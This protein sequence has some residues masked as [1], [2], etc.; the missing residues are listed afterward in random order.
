MLVALVV[1]ALVELKFKLVRR[2]LNDARADAVDL[3]GATFGVLDFAHL[4][5][6]LNA[7][8][9]LIRGLKVLNREFPLSTLLTQ[10]HTAVGL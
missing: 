8:H 6:E 3:G 9:I 10:A 4:L 7:V 1:L 2:L 5:G